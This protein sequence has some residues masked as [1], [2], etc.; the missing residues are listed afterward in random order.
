MADQD[1]VTEVQPAVTQQ[2][3]PGKGD[4]TVVGP[5]APGLETVVASEARL[6][7]QQRVVLAVLGGLIGL[8]ALA[9]VVAAATSRRD[10]DRVA[11]LAPPSTTTSTT[12][13]ST[14]T[15]EAPATATTTAKA[16]STSTTAPATTVPTTGPQPVIT[17][18][19]AVLRPPRRASV[20]PLA[21]GGCVSLA[22]EGWTATCEQFTGKGGA[23]LAWLIEHQ[24]A[25]G[26]AT[27]RRAMVLRQQGTGRAKT[28]TWEVV[29]EVR[30][31]AGDR[32]A[33]INARVIDLSGD[34]AVDV[35]FGFRSTGTA[36]VL[37]VD[38]V[39]GPGTVSV[40]AEGYKGSARISTG[41]LDI[42][43]AIIGPGEANCCP[44]KVEHSTIRKQGGTWRVVAKKD[45]KP[46]EVPPSQL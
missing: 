4:A 33:D 29:L 6:S 46:G 43:N 15:T 38:V 11:A 8:L 2:S 28:P 16:T 37:S 7:H 39:E 24:P 14:T 20:R 36:M 45:E 30:D 5:P 41:Q 34:G 42:W 22:D 1:D 32:F 19:G 35:A 17:A 25:K 10:S 21:A 23:Q 12:A 27:G 13:P 18:R 40:H 31:D 26:G 3:T 44:S 9:L